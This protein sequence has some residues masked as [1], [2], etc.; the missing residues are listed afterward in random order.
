MEVAIKYDLIQQHG[1]W[2]SIIDPDTGD[3]KAD[4]IQGMSNVKEFF[5]DE[6]NEEVLSFV[7]DYIDNKIG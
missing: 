3:I 5:M 2:F 1:A 6:E 4:K 7:E